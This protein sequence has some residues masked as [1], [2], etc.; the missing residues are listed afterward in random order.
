MSP[1]PA[2][3][4]V[5]VNFC[6]LWSAFDEMIDSEVP[7]AAKKD[8]RLS[9][10]VFHSPAGISIHE[11]PKLCVKS[12]LKCP[13]RGS[14]RIIPIPVFGSISMTSKNILGVSSW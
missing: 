5:I 14:P 12:D 4:A 8:A 10:G 13:F 11:L 7:L 9:V 1:P 3:P 6:F 2:K